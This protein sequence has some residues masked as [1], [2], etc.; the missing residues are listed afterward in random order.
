MRVAEGASVNLGRL[1][2]SP[3]TGTHADA[4]F[5]VADTGAAMADVPLDAYIGP[6]RVVEVSG[7]RDAA[8][9]WITLEDAHCA[10]SPG[11]AERILFRTGCWTDPQRF[12]ERFPGFSPDAADLLLDSGVLLVGTDAP[13]VDSFESKDLPVHHRLRRRGAVN[14]ENLF[15]DRVPEGDYELIALPL[16][17]EGADGSPVRAVLRTW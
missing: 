4:P 17:L 8:E 6:A 14:L 9:A 7:W 11:P 15:L 13:S 5:H 12:P 2:L 10:L 1:E 16:R 3:H